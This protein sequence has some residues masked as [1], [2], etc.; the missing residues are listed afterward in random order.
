M[1]PSQTGKSECQGSS[2][3]RATS[4]SLSLD[5]TIVLVN[6]SAR[7]YCVLTSGDSPESVGSERD[8]PLRGPFIGTRYGLNLP[9]FSIYKG[10]GGVHVL[11]VAWTSGCW[12]SRTNDTPGSLARVG[13]LIVEGFRPALD[14]I[15]GT[16]LHINLALGSRFC[17]KYKSEIGRGQTRQP[18]RIPSSKYFQGCRHPS[19]F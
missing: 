15:N 16:H 1:C 17:K 18:N 4:K 10:R 2:C 7:A 3:C 12:Q 11:R 5:V 13:E 14:A 6:T 9:R 19:T 8:P